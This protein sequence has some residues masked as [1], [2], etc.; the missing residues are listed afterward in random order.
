M[1]LAFGSIPSW[2]SF[3]IMIALSFFIDS[4]YILSGR[5]LLVAMLAHQ[6]IGT[7][8]TFLNRGEANVFELG[9]LILIVTGL[10]MRESKGLLHHQE[11]LDA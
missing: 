11:A 4:V 2:Y 6:S 1:N 3:S 7:V 5:N 9:I 8:F 10:R